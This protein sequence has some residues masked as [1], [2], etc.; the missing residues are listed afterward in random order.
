MTNQ[1]NVVLN[2]TIIVLLDRRDS[3]SIGCNDIFATNMMDGKN[4]IAKV[5]FVFANALADR[6]FNQIG[7]L[8]K[9]IGVING[10]HARCKVLET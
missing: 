4:V 8:V 6:A 5:H 3:N 2:L 10:A 1:T 7:L 9:P